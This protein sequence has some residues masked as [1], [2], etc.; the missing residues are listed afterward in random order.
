LPGKY[1]IITATYRLTP[2][3]PPY[4]ILKTLSEQTI[5]ETATVRLQCNR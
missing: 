2:F 4:S 1:I 5:T 3:F